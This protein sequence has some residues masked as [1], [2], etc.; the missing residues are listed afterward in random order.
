MRRFC[1]IL[2][3]LWATVAAVAEPVK[4][5]CVGNSITFGYKLPDRM[6]NSYPAQLQRMLGPGYE[7]GNFG[8]SG[9][10]LLRRGHNPYHKLREFQQALDFTP[11][12]AVIHLGVN[13]TDPRDWPN[14]NSEFVNDYLTIIDSLRSRNPGVRIIVARLT[15]LRAGHPRFATGTR[16]WRIKVQDAIERVAQAAGAEVIDFDTPLRD[17]Q[18]LIFD[19]IHPNVEG[20]TIMAE[21][22]RGAIT[23]NYGGLRLPSI[24]QNGMVVQRNRRLPLRGRADAHTPVTVTID[25]CTYRAVA[26]NRGDWEVTL[27]PLVT[28]PEYTLTVAAPSD[29]L[30]FDGILA[31]EVWMAS[32]Q[33]NMEFYL[34]NA[35]GGKEA[36]ASA[37]D[38]LL[39]FYDMKEV[40]RTDNVEWSDS[41]QALMNRLEH[42][43]PARWQGVAP[44][45]AGT[46]SAVAY[47]FG[48]ALRDSLRV[49]VG[50][51][52]NA[53]GGSP[54][55]AWIDIN[56]LEREMPGILNNVTGN[57]YLQ[58]WVQGRIRRNTADRPMARHPYQPSY[59]FAAGIR[60]L[61]GFP[62]A[63]T[64][65]YQGESNAHNTELHER[66]FPMLVNSWRREFGSPHM[67][68]YYVQLSSLNRPSWPE[69]RDSQR[70]MSLQI[71]NVGMAVSSDRGDSLD[72][73]PRDKRPVG[74][75]LARLALNGVYGLEVPCRGPEVAKAQTR[76][77]KLTL[78]FDNATQLSAADSSAV[79]TFEVAEID[80]VYYPADVIIEGNKIILSNMNVKTPKYAR[81]GWQPFTR[82]NL[83]NEHGL[84]AST[85]RVEAEGNEIEPGV[86]HGLSGSFC[87]VLNGETVIGGGAN[88]PCEDPLSSNAQKA[89][90]QGIYAIDAKGCWRRIGSLPVA[91]AYGASAQTP[92][93]PV[94]IAPDGHVWLVEADASLK[95][96]PSLPVAIDNAAAAFADGAVYLAG[97]NAGGVPSRALYRLRLG[98]DK[99]QKLRDMPGEPR[100]QPVM[101]A[102]NGDLYLWGGFAPKHGKKEASLQTAGLRYSPADNRW[103]VLP[104]PLSPEGEEVSLG[105]G[106]AVTLGDGTIAAFGGVNKDVFLAALQCQAP[107]YLL[108]PVEWYRFNP[109]IFLFKDGEW[110]SPIAGEDTARAG[111]AATVGGNTVTVSGG[112]LKPRIRSNQTLR[113]DL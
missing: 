108:H 89:T 23:G 43:R 54:A 36:A 45:N 100:V 82:A 7:V 27:H 35:V 59:L 72:V 15:P 87:G 25:G 60:P 22:V 10:T 71:D 93:G 38:P 68:F 77:N 46:L 79:R 61:K 76:G 64:I 29:T 32:G 113:I 103:S 67:P 41:V 66:L 63:G 31:G 18:E 104:A 90:Y 70:R 69:F 40:G 42:Y 94:W 2:V 80:G 83:V 20:A 97:G 4:V 111:A 9:A 95:E 33:S 5:A 8:H 12:I 85:F 101:T 52:S 47:W 26:D 24:W 3:W 106:C 110:Q 51:I 75:R 39:R 99:W 92:G 102:L 1:L 21:T 73:H 49:P 91:T 17:R 98:E 44:D 81:Y 13:D 55:E 65:W 109:Y 74:E 6:V 86:E 50:I 96:L 14:H 84:P 37:A 56:T 16:D 62:V 107:D 57:D 53:V 105:G 112:E 58:P 11:D 30:R 78:T 19:E 34:R 28:G 88:F 48:R